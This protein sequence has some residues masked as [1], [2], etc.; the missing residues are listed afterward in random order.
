MARAGGWRLAICTRLRETSLFACGLG[1]YL[2][3]SAGG[4]S[5]SANAATDGVNKVLIV[6]WGYE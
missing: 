3:F 6:K 5:I 2:G 4:Y 1:H